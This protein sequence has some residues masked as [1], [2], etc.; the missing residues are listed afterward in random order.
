[1]IFLIS[2][3]LITLK[4]HIWPH[5]LDQRTNMHFSMKNY[6]DKGIR[7]GCT[8]KNLNFP[9]TCMIMQ[10]TEFIEILVNCWITNLPVGWCRHHWIFASMYGIFINS[11][12]SQFSPEITPTHRRI[13][14]ARPV[15]STLDLTNLR[16]KFSIIWL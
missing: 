16:C 11:E 14:K 1:M 6:L 2:N 13:A 7:R 15:R 8:L 9:L 12:F 3:L 5:S 4:I 10:K